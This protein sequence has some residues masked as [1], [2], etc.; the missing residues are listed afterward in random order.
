[1]RDPDHSGFKDVSPTVSVAV[2][3][4]GG[5][6]LIGRQP[7]NPMRRRQLL[8]TRGLS[9]PWQPNGEEQSR[10]WIHDAT[11]QA[12]TAGQQPVCLRRAHKPKAL[13][14]NLRLFAERHAPLVGTSRL[15][16][17]VVDN[18]EP[19]HQTVAMSTGHRRT[20]A[21]PPARAERSSPRAAGGWGWAFVVLLLLS[22]GMASVPGGQDPTG[23]VRDFY[24]QHAGVVVVAQVVGLLAAAAFVPFALTLRRTAVRRKGA[25]VAAGLGVAAAAALTAVP[26]LWLTAVAGNGADGLVHALAV[27]SDLTDV[28]L[29]ATIALWA[30]AVLLAGQPLWFNTLAGAVGLL[31]LA[32]ALLLLVGSELLELVAPLAFV[33][34]VGVLSTLILLHRSPLG[35]P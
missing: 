17:G 26:V 1:M 27:A 30:T 20:A 12:R 2:T 24:V 10:A 25:L 16:T 11:M 13:A 19:Q 5:H 14:S 32:R 29:F 18:L 8:R 35:R 21:S 34:L 33:S 22:A 28:L 9:H 7:Q 3:E 4:Q 31:A 23:T 15:P 6:P